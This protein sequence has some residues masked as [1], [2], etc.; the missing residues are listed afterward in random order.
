MSFF[1]C[2]L[3]VLWH[4]A[5]GLTI[6]CFLGTFVKVLLSYKESLRLIFLSYKDLTDA[7]DKLCAFVI[8]MI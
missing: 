5:V 7:L 4:I 2:S 3:S 8:N 6:F 1:M